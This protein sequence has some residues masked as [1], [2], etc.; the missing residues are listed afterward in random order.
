MPGVPGSG[1]PPPKRDS[2]RRRANTPAKGPATKGRAAVAKR[3]PPDPS[4]HPA[5][6]LWYDSLADSGQSEFYSSS[7]WATAWVSAEAMS[8][9]LQPQPMSVGKGDEAHIEMVLLPPKAA[10]LA[11]W[12]KACTALMATEGDRRRLRLELDRPTPEKP[13]EAPGV[14]EL[15]AYRRRLTGPA[16]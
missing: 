3:Q 14:A 10:T 1:G 9:E 5:M 8:R 7:D 6:T 11:A 16:G 2:Q 12:L 4:W 13:K 15:D